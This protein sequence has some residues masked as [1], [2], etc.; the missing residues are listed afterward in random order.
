MSTDGRT[1]L[2]AQSLL[3]AALVA[4]LALW[5]PGPSQLAAKDR[6]LASVHSN[7][8]KEFNSVRHI[9]TQKFSTLERSK[10]VIFDVREDD[11][12]AVSHLSRAIRV[13]PDI[14]AGE[15]M[16][17]YAG[18]IAG[19]TVIVYCS[20]GVRSSAL[21]ER[22]SPALKTSGESKVYNLT[23]GI[24]QWHNEKRPLTRG[25][26]STPYVHPYNRSWGRLITDEALISY[27]PR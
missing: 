4:A 9:S 7:V 12:Y 26:Q 6:T 16:R 25:A 27:T 20:V 2:V 13:D 1:K 24:F 21:A 11:E 18:E 17:K 23:G 5:T 14:A 19:K 3:I 10:L 22:I 15:F 8:V